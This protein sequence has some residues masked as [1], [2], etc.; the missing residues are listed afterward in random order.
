MLRDDM[1]NARRIAYAINKY[2]HGELA[3]RYDEYNDYVSYLVRN[4][5]LS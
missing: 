2:E 3:N 4:G 5:H 1:N